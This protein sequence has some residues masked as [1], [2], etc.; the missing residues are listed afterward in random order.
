MIIFD[1]IL[2]TPCSLF[3]VPC[4]LFPVPCSLCYTANSHYFHLLLY[5]MPL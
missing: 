1:A 4:S 3:P 2:P 5:S